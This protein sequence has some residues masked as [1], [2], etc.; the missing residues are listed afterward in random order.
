MAQAWQVLIIIDAHTYTCVGIMRYT[1]IAIAVQYCTVYGDAMAPQLF[2]IC[3][4]GCPLD[5]KCAYQYDKHGRILFY[6]N[7]QPK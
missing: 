6:S 7:E 3:H 2:S 4:N 5:K 1:A